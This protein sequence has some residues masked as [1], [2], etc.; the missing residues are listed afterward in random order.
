MSIVISGSLVHDHI[1]NFPDSFKNHIMPDQIHILNV[2]FIV[3]KLE[4]S[5]GGTAGN[6][7][8]T[9]KLLGADPLIVSGV[10]KDG[11]EYLN[12][13]KKYGMSTKYILEDKK[14]MTASA[15]ITTDADDNQITA[16]FGGPLDLARDIEITAMRESLTLALISPTH[17]DT[18]IKHMLD[19]REKGVKA[20]FDPGQQITAFNEAELKKMISLAHFVIGNDYEMKLLQEKTGWDAQ[21]ILKNTK[22]LI[23]TLGEKGSVI[24]TSEGETTE[25]TCCAPQS[26]DDP[27]GAGDAYRAGFF[28]GFEQGYPFKTCAQMGSTAA[29]YAI[30]TFGTQ[31]HEFTEKEFCDRYEKAF[32]EKISLAR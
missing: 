8:Y 16:F 31:A 19:A 29:S 28:V 25:A 23:T 1:M 27:T 14:Q 15:H 7:A 10:G 26:Y 24:V 17:K 32:D 11:E 30:E 13:F 18:M 3:D 21:E 6:I 22:V 12:H 4:R 20:V 9:M 2:S 5:W